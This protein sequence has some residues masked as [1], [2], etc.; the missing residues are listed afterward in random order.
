MARVSASLSHTHFIE[1]ADMPL[2]APR[3]AALRRS[4]LE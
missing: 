3:T 2:R 1:L 4:T